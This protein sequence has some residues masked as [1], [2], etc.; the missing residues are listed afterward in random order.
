MP[1]GCIGG[2]AGRLTAWLRETAGVHDRAELAAR[3]AR[4]ELRQ[5]HNALWLARVR[6]RAPV[7]MLTKLPEDDVRALGFEKVESLGHAMARAADLAG[8]PARTCVVPHGNVT[9]VRGA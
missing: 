8:R 5:P 3:I 4:G 7:L 2:S 9:V 1:P 6:E